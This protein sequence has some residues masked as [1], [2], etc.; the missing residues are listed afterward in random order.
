MNE[1]DGR[2]LDEY[3]CAVL[4]TIAQQAVGFVTVLGVSAGLVVAWPAPTSAVDTDVSIDTTSIDFGMVDIGATSAPLDA[5][6]TNGGGDPFGPIDMFGGAPGGPFNASQNCQGV[7]LAPGGTCAVTYTFAPTG[8]G[9][10]SGESRFTISETGTEAGGEDF[11]VALAGVGYDPTPTTTTTTTTTSTTTTTTTTP[12]ATTTATSP[13]QANATPAAAP[14][15]TPATT[16]STTT[17]TLVAREPLTGVVTEL[18]PALVVKVDNVDAAPQS[19]LNQADVVFEEIV[20]GR[21]TRFAAVFNSAEA[22]PVGPIRSGRTQDVDL[23]MSLNDP[24]LAYSGA[25]DG[26]NAAL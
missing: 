14:A 7:T 4:R 6:I 11:T 24:A 9:P 18:R 25:N 3:N 16:T 5:T 23:L 8:A 19:G 22:N 21:A 15:P 10:A 2:G 17:T 1:V 12:S 13:G 20:E 26:V